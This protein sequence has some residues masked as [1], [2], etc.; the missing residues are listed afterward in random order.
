MKTYTSKQKTFQPK[1]VIVRYDNWGK[2]NNSIIRGHHRG[3][4]KGEKKG[5]VEWLV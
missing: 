4:V 2:L 5:Q 1:K 3:A